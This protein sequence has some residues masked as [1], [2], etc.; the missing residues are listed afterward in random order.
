[1]PVQEMIARGYTVSVQPPT[2][3]ADGYHIVYAPDPFAIKTG[4]LWW[5]AWPKSNRDPGSR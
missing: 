5:P 2:D 4:S 1:M 3:A